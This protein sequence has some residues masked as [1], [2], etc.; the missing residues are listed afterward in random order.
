MAKKYLKRIFDDELEE[1]LDIIG[2]VLIVGPKWCGKTTTAEQHAKSVLKLQDP[3][4]R[5]NYLKT[6]DIK[7]SLL[8]KGEKP[9]LI[10]EWQVAPVL[11]DAV[12]TSVDELEGD[13]LY[14]LTGSTSVDESKI[15]HSG[16]GRIHRLLM[17][18]MSLFESGESNGKISILDLFKNPNL[19]IDGIQS[20][21]SYNL[22]LKNIV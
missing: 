3:D 15:M 9:R 4:N 11:W 19:N 1:V 22:L 14:I 21:A 18:P 5:E 8:L 2:A 12:R 13:G 17:R 7:P 20:N 10:D 6:A 16:T